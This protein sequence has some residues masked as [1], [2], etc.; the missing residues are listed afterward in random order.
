MTSL[1]A[2]VTPWITA[3]GFHPFEPVGGV[4]DEPFGLGRSRML[5]GLVNCPLAGVIWP[6]LVIN[7]CVPTLVMGL[8]FGF[9]FGSTTELL[10]GGCRS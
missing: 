1:T 8:G 4:E 10:A 5:N 3:P 9:G 7:V 6:L 2:V